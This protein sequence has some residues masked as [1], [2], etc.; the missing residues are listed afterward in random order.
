MSAT[1]HAKAY[2]RLTGLYPRAF[3]HEYGEDLVATFAAQIADDGPARSWLRATRDLSVTVPLQHLEAH[4]HRPAPQS[5]RTVV[6]VVVGVAATVVGIAIGASFYALLLVMLAA[7]AFLIAVRS[8][9]SGSPATTTPGER[10]WKKA[11][12][13]GT[14]LLVVQI[15]ILNTPAADHELTTWQ[16]ALMMLT[17][18][19]SIALIAAGALLG[20]SGR[21]RRRNS[22]RPL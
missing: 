8:A 20:I 12:V 1:R 17:L 16:W 9:R 7:V 18:L 22:P 4:V 2:R 11:L 13:V 19:S 5:T 21:T 3:R 6:G 10:S 15:I 14:V